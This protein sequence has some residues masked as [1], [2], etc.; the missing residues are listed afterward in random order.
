MPLTEVVRELQ[1]V[2]SAELLW[3]RDM[4]KYVNRNHD[5]VLH[6]E[7][8]RL[9]EFDASRDAF[10]MEGQRRRCLMFSEL[11]CKCKTKELYEAVLQEAGRAERRK[12]GG[13]EEFAKRARPEILKRLEEIET[14]CREL[15]E[16]QLRIKEDTADGDENGKNGD[17]KAVTAD[18][19]G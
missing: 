9:A 10:T 11:E 7:R 1:K 6:A 13:G 16:Y 19:G 14:H 18:S 4:R 3:L 15:R 2:P 8:R 17:K 12:K 5:G